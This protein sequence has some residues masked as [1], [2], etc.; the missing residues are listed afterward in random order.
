MGER[1]RIAAGARL[2]SSILEDSGSIIRDETCLPAFL[3][4][5]YTVQLFYLVESG[6]P[7]VVKDTQLSCP[8]RTALAIREAA[9]VAG[10]MDPFHPNRANGFMNVGVMMTQSNPYGAVEMHMKALEIRL[11]STKYAEDQ[12]H[13]LALNYLNIGRALWLAKRHEEAVEALDKCIDI[14][15]DRERLTSKRFPQ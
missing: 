2:V 7:F 4:D 8:A 13:G 3:A 6:N 15:K 9:V 12:V 5:L 1:G 11:G 10:T 14:I